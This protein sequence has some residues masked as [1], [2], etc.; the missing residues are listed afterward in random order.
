MK[1]QECRSPKRVDFGRMQM[2]DRLRISYE[3]GLTHA[4]T[5]IDGDELRFILFEA[6]GNAT[7]VLVVYSK[8][9]STDNDVKPPV[10]ME[11]L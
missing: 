11:E 8:E 4:A 10:L 1:R 9:T 6:N 7:D 5:P 2:S 3:K